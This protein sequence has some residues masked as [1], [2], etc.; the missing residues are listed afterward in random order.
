M[1]SSNVLDNKDQIEITNNRLSSGGPNSHDDSFEILNSSESQ[2]QT[3]NFDIITTVIRCLI[4]GMKTPDEGQ[5]DH[6]IHLLIEHFSKTL[7]RVYTDLLTKHKDDITELNR[8]IL[9]DI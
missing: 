8:F 9:L 3:K 5:V 7:V 4:F 1:T 2:D 6:P